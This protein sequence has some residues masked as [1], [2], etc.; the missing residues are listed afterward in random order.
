MRG[1]SLNPLKWLMNNRT[2]H[3]MRQLGVLE[4]AR[5]VMA[6]EKPRPESEESCCS[7]SSSMARLSS[8]SPPVDASATRRSD[9]H[10]MDAGTT[11][12]PLLPLPAPIQ[13]SQSDAQGTVGNK[14]GF[15]K[16]TKTNSNFKKIENRLT[17]PISIF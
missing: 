11:L 1:F 17:K 8:V 16:E 14:N 6:L 7:F 5:N 9:G 10:E 2:T 4:V 12:R 15:F 13:I 3:S